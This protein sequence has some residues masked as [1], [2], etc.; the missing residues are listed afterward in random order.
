MQSLEF[1]ISKPETYVY[2]G[3]SSTTWF[4]DWISKLCDPRPEITVNWNSLNSFVL[5]ILPKSG[6]NKIQVESVKFNPPTEIQCGKKQSASFVNKQFTWY[7]QGYFIQF[8]Y[9]K[10]ERIKMRSKVLNEKETWSSFYLYRPEGWQI[11][12]VISL[13]TGNSSGR[14]FSRSTCHF[15]AANVCLTRTDADSALV[16]TRNRN[17]RQTRFFIRSQCSRVVLIRRWLSCPRVIP[18]VHVSLKRVDAHVSKGLIVW[19]KWRVNWWTVFILTQKE[20]NP[21]SKKATSVYRLSAGKLR[22]FPSPSRIRFFF[23]A[24]ARGKPRYFPEQRMVI[25]KLHSNTL[26]CRTDS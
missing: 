22:R 5:R 16:H 20:T 6:S 21:S 24:F 18:D 17:W 15:C 2:F 3:T 7:R 14:T 19:R 26:T 8:R 13:R 23:R 4:G 12:R 10:A 25:K 1:H 9:W 11:V